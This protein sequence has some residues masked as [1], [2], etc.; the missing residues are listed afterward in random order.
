MGGCLVR[1]TTVQCAAVW[2]VFA[3]SIL[4]TVAVYTTTVLA[5]WDKAYPEMTFAWIQPGITL[6]YMLFISVAGFL[7][8]WRWEEIVVKVTNPDASRAK[9]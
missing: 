6:G 2:A 9:K 1:G 4:Y 5:Y 3:S 7:M 8:F